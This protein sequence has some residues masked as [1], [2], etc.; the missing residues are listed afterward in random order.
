MEL[1]SLVAGA[2]SLEPGAGARQRRG[3]RQ[4]EER[5]S[6]ARGEEEERKSLAREER[7]S[8]ARGED[9]ASRRRGSR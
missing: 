6:L 8:L 2:W 7:K 4:A 3:R 5:K 1:R 9:V